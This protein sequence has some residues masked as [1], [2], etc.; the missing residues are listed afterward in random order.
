MS[1]NESDLLSRYKWL[2]EQC[3]RVNEA[4]ARCHRL[5]SEPTAASSRLVLGSGRGHP[6]TR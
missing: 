1:A 2:S 4:L 5:R 3:C 6:S